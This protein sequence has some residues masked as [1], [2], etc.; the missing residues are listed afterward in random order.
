MHLSDTEVWES[1]RVLEASSCHPSYTEDDQCPAINTNSP[2]LDNSFNSIEHLLH[3]ERGRSGGEAST[4]CLGVGR[5]QCWQFI[6]ASLP[7]KTLKG[8]YVLENFISEKEE[9]DIVCFLDMDLRN[10]WRL[11]TFNGLHLGKGYG[12]ITNLRKRCVCPANFEMPKVLMPILERMRESV[13]VLKD[14]CPN[15]TNAIDYCKHKGHWLKPHVDDR[16]ISGTILVNLSLCGDCRMT[17][18]RER[19]PC[20]IYKVLLRRRCIQILTG[21]SRYSFT[22]SILNDDLLDPRRVS[23]TFRQSSNP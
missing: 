11:S 22:H 16:Q 12:M 15:E 2:K 21:E 6:T 14:F 20:E 3:D 9:Q 17:Y 23:M 10:P 19:G 8:H 7:S 4:P 18:A 5:D 13:S 1:A